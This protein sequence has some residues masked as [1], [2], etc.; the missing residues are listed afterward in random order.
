MESGGGARA[1]Y[2]GLL[3]RYPLPTKMVT[4]GFIG[5]GGDTTCQLGIERRAQ[6]DTMRSA[7]FFMLGSCL[8]A[9]WYHL[10]FAAL[11]WRIPGAGLVAGLK[12][13]TVDQ[14]IMP[15]L[16]N[17]FYLAALM[18]LEGRL[19][20]WLPTMQDGYLEMLKANWLLWVPFQLANF[21]LVPVQLQVLFMNCVSVV[22]VCYMSCTN[23]AA[24]AAMMLTE[25][26][27]AKEGE[28]GVG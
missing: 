1:W 22:W 10:W 3:E 28:T 21:G 2:L 6:I 27:R 23:S 7:R 17:P 9:P 19:H 11:A 24:V 20:L 8:T 13:V 12:K 26:E 4:A 5:I 18:A 15:H 14:L 16:F 25:A